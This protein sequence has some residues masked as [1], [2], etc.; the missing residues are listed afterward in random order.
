MDAQ[1][2]S[3]KLGVPVIPI[4]ASARQGLQELKAALTSFQPSGAQLGEALTEQHA[5]ERLAQRYRRSKELVNGVIE[6]TSGTHGLTE[7]IDRWVLNRWPGVPFFLLM[8]YLMFT[9][10]V[11]MG[12]VFIDFFDL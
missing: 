3:E 7:R 1:R 4:I 11:S 2:L 10:A 6:F 8:M 9:V 12:A 5:T